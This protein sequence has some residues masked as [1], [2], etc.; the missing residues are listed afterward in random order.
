MHTARRRSKI[1]GFTLY[2][3]MVCLS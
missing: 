2:A 1:A 3:F